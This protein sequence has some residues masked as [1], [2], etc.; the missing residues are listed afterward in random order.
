MFNWVFA[1][2]LT[3]LTSCCTELFE[4]SGIRGIVGCDRWTGGTGSSL[5]VCCDCCGC[6]GVVGGWDLDSCVIGCWATISLANPWLDW[7][8]TNELIFKRSLA[9]GNKNWVLVVCLTVLTSCSIESFQGSEAKGSG[10]R[11]IVGC[12]RWTGG[13]G[14]GLVVCCKISCKIG[15][16]SSNNSSLFGIGVNSTSIMLS[17]WSLLFRILLVAFLRFNTSAFLRVASAFN[18]GSNPIGLIGRNGIGCCCGSL[19]NS[20]CWTSRSLFL[21]YRLYR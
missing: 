6:C 20:C 10:I 2:C 4:E 5:V 11:G 16:E 13:T 1:V 9:G 8:C 15:N 3:M 14:R 19:V 7:A 12:D 17:I 18:E 21:V